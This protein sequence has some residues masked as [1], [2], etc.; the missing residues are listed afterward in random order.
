MSISV[1]SLFFF[2]STPRQDTAEALE[3]DDEWTSEDEAEAA[4]AVAKA[5]EEAAE[6]ARAAAA[7]AEAQAALKAQKVSH[8]FILTYLLITRIG[9]SDFR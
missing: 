5:A 6:E 1:S 7:L 2:L 8:V 3:S 4:A 9:A